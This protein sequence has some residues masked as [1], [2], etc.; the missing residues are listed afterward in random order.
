MRGAKRAI[1]AVRILARDN[2]IPR[3]LRW[4]VVL[5]VAPVPGPF[6]EAVLLIAA[7][8]LFTFYREQMREA[9]REAGSA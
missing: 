9:W 1:R 7:S 4:L 2:R 8:L 3:P 6:D 5:G